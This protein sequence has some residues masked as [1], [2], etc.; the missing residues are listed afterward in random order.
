MYADSEKRCKDTTFFWNLQTE[1]F[2]TFLHFVNKVCILLIYCT[3]QENI[4]CWKFVNFCVEK[5]FVGKSGEISIFFCTFAAENEII[6]Q[7]QFFHSHIKHA[8][9]TTFIGNI[10]ARLDDKGR[11]FI[12]AAYRKILA[13]Y[14]SRKV[15]LHREP[16]NECLVFYPEQVW[17]QRVS[18]LQEKLDEW[19]PDDQMLLMQF[20]SEAQLLEPDNQGRVLIQKR[21]LE[22]IGAEGDVVFVGMLNRFAL[23]SPQRFEERKLEKKDFAAALRKKMQRSKE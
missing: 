20:M 17:N 19:D 14:A 9:M 18:E 4:F 5:F 13:E 15:V 2:P 22:Q 6:Q 21:D 12:P 16:E 11:I 23:W 10:E 7:F 1:F 3:L 8:Q